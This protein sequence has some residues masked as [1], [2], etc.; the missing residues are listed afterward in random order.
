MK[1]RDIPWIISILVLIVTG[2]M[3][4]YATGNHID[5][6]LVNTSIWGGFLASLTGSIIGVLLFLSKHDDSARI[7]FGILGCLIMT[8]FFGL[9]ILS[10]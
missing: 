7:I 10:I 2:F 1:T 5:P 4:W 8:G 3:I 9:A 6:S